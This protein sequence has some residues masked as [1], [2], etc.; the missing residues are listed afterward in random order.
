MNI[1]TRNCRKY[2]G[3]MWRYNLFWWMKGMNAVFVDRVTVKIKKDN[4]S[5]PR[6]TRG[7]FALISKSVLTYWRS[8][9]KM[10]LR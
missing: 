3:D 5:Y 6:V 2:C 4:V 9:S 10:D 7:R 1:W 8:I